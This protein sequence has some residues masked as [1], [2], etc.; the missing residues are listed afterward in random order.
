MENKLGAISLSVDILAK[1]N[2]GL[3]AVELNEGKKPRMYVD[4]TMQGLL[5]FGKEMS[6]EETYMAWYNNIDKKSVSLVND[7]IEKMIA[8]IHSEVQY[9]WCQ[10]NGNTMIIR[11]GGVRN[12]KYTEGIRVEGTHQ[13]V[14][15]IIHFE[16]S[17]HRRHIVAGLSEDYEGIMYLNSDMTKLEVLRSNPALIS[18]VPGWD[19][20]NTVLGKKRKVIDYI[21]IP[22]DRA[23]LERDLQ[24][25]NVLAHLKKTGAYRI[26][27]RLAYSNGDIHHY[28]I[29]IVVHKDD[30][31]GF[32]RGYIV[33][34]RNIDQSYA[35]EQKRLQVLEEMHKAQEA[36]KLKSQFVQN[37]SHDV[38]TPL[39][40]IV[41]YSQLLGMPD[42]YLSDAERAE[43]V[44]YINGSAEMLTMLVDDILS[45]SDV[46]NGVLKISK[47]DFLCNDICNKAVHCSMM[48]VPAG[49]RLYFTSDATES[50][51]IY[52]DPRRV[53]QILVNLLSNSCKHTIKGEI[54]VHCSIKEKP[55]NAIFSV[56]DTGDGVPEGMEE[57]IFQRFTS[58]EGKSG[59]GLGLSICRDLADRLGGEI[60]LDTT[61]K[62]GAR[63]VLSLPMK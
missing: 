27:F 51:T 7:S 45:M 6:P 28:Q 3:W 14:S 1:A 5:G 16:D 17:E 41:G 54:H 12:Y 19:E 58:L 23:K 11:C 60:Y 40:A 59:H 42:G 53:E 29:K 8:G 18:H 34:W 43:F 36:N 49:V 55:G 63:F 35:E 4:D 52:T 20:D 31:T 15:R 25:D 10:P 38:R 50:E 39:N 21:C 22:Q 30:D 61:Y 32:V 44:D 47:R 48:R 2:I 57:K 9:P 46:E 56:T 37:M 13:D 26:K 62:N 24:E 33:G